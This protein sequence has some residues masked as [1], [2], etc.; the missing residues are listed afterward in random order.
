MF[1]FNTYLGQHFGRFRQSVNSLRHQTTCRASDNLGDVNITRNPKDGTVYVCSPV[2]YLPL[3]V[4]SMLTASGVV[5]EFEADEGGAGITVFVATDEAYADL[6][7]TDTLQSITADQ[8]AVFL[9]FHVLRSL[10]SLESILN[11]VQ[12]TL[13]SVLVYLH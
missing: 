10:G 9:K 8:R 13:A 6:P 7:V 2:S 1:Y 11:P 3:N 12:P 5:K 4:A